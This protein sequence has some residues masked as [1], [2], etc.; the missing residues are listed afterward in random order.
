MVL[1]RNIKVTNHDDYK[2]R[3]GL[4]A[5]GVLVNNEITKVFSASKFSEY[6]NVFFNIANDSLNNSNVTIW[7]SDKENPTREDLLEPIIAIEGGLTYV[8]GPVTISKNENVFIK[9]DNDDTIYRLYGYDERK[10]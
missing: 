3:Y 5:K 6:V 9:A 2:D 1:N 7:I 8:R 4:L 10:L